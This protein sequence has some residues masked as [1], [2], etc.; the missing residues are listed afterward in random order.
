MKLYLLNY[1]WNKPDFL[2]FLALR[3]FN[4]LAFSFTNP[5]LQLL[6][7]LDF[8]W[9][10][11]DLNKKICWCR[12]LLMRICFLSDFGGVEKA[13]MVSASAV[14]K[15]YNGVEVGSRRDEKKGFNNTFRVERICCVEDW[16]RK[17]RIIVN[18]KPIRVSHY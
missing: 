14:R 4:F 6:C 15:G 12:I 11:Y 1:L 2:C 8:W 13:L 16:W 18:D 17:N 10:R 5:M 9:V 7:G 3:F